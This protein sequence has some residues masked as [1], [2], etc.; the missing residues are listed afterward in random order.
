MMI[1]ENIAFNM[2]QGKWYKTMM[3]KIQEN[4]IPTD[5]KTFDLY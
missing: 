5:H 1:M 3:S 4:W 2:V